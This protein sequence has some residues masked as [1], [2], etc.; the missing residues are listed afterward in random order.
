M[1]GPCRVLLA[2]VLA[3]RVY[4]TTAGYRSI[5]AG[6]GPPAI[7]ARCSRRRWDWEAADRLRPQPLR[8]PQDHVGEQ[9]REARC[10]HGCRCASG[11]SRCRIGCH[12]VEWGI[13]RFI[14]SCVQR[15][16][17]RSPGVSPAWVRAGG[18]VAWMAGRRETDALKP[19]DTAIFGMVSESPGCN[20]S[21][22]TGSLERAKLRRPSP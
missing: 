21:E 11:S 10:C 1:A 9:H 3:I 13:S 14:P 12:H 7:L 17:T 18:P 19:S 4:G 6:A 2:T 15:R 16:L 8:Q 20:G 5:R 22:R